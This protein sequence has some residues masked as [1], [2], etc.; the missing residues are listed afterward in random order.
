MRAGYDR[1]Y[2]DTHRAPIPDLPVEYE[3]AADE[4]STLTSSV[5]GAMFAL[6]LTIVAGVVLH[7]GI[8]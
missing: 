2:T 8:A 4:R 7:L 5:P 1:V 6:L 3:R